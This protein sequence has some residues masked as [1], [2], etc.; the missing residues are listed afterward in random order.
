MTI[1]EIYDQ[2]KEIIEKHIVN[3]YNELLQSINEDENYSLADD[4][5]TE[6]FDEIVIMYMKNTTPEA[7]WERI[8]DLL[9]ENNLNR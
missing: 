8:I 5:A 2:K 9:S 1:K 3:M 6:L 4:E 7:E